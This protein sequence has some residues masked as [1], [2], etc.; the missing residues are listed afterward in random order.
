[1]KIGAF[2]GKRSGFNPIYNPQPFMLS[3]RSQAKFENQKKQE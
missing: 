1:M 2:K 3:P